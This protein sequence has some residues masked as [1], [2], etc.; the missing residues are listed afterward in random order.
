V[1]FQIRQ[2]W[3]IKIERSICDYDLKSKGLSLSRVNLIPQSLYFDPFMDLQ[4][5]LGFYLSYKVV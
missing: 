5:I 2:N 4:V 3:V 1:C